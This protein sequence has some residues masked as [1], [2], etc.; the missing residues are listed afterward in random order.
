MTIEE[1]EAEISAVPRFG[2][3]AGLANLNLYL[4]ALG[5]PERKLR[6]IHVAGTNGKGSVCAYLESI[7]RD[8]GYKTALFTSPHLVRI[9]ER[10]R[11]N[12]RECEDECL[13]AAWKKVRHMMEES[14]EG[15][16]P[17]TYF[18]ILFLMGVLIFRE[19]NPDY[20]IME[21]GLGGRLDATVLTCPV[22]SVITSISLD[23]TEILGDTIEAIAEEK[24]GII[25]PGIPVAALDEGNGAVS[26]IRKKAEREHSPFYSVETEKI[27][28]SKKSENTIDFSIK[29]RY[30]RDNPLS[31]RGNAVYQVYNGALA[32][33]A[34]RILLPELDTEHIRRGLMA[35]RWEGRMEEVLPGVYVD[36]AHN[37][38]AIEQICRMAE[39]M[40]GRWNLLFAVCGDKDYPAMIRKLSRLP[41]KKIYVTGTG[42]QREADIEEIISCF[43]RESSC[44]IDSFK[45]PEQALLAALHEKNAKEERLLCLGSLYLVGELKRSITYILE[46]EA[47]S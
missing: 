34:V 28:F 6:V 35:M 27:T 10:F 17:L 4:E 11:I 23:H 18:E 15:R 24:A 1:M 14:K 12:F 5:H 3:G 21:T 29:N 25:K 36:G 47:L 32:V 39:S 19:E 2:D 37:P 8:A 31:I 44:P 46:S 20:C 43:R 41:W 40:D 7:L 30:Y 45:K 16:K 26:V 38:G 42:Q 22:L 33:T 13:I 9:N